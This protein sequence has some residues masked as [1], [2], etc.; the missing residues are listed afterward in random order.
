MKKAKRQNEEDTKT[1]PGS[2]PRLLTPVASKNGFVLVSVLWILAILTVITVGFGRRSMLDRRA[3][4]FS[5]DHSKALCMARG[6]VVR[7]VVELQNRTV[8]NALYHQIHRTGPTQYWAK[9]IDMMAQGFYTKLDGNDLPAPA[10]GS[11]AQGQTR[12]YCKATIRDEEGLISINTEK[13][14]E[15]LEEIDG[16]DYSLIRKINFRLTGTENYDKPTP[17]QTVEELRFL[18]DIDDDLW[19]GDGTRL[20]LKD[21]LTCWNFKN[22]NVNNFGDGLININ[23]A[24]REVLECIPEIDE[25]IVES[26]LAYRAG[27]DGEP[28]TDD[29]ADFIDFDHI[30]RYWLENPIPEE[31]IGQLKK[32]CKVE[33]NCFT[34]QGIATRRQGKVRALCSATVYVQDVNATIIKWREESLDS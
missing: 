9:P 2:N 15:L 11:A 8:V 33:S 17:F 28:G 27:T 30:N 25:D 7:G 22:G 3:A 32:Y 24:P 13:G 20:G 1:S 12:D 16:I 18:G 19:F 23:T 10:T 5:F 31:F 34:I 6:A 21:I 4:A 26:I 29:D 14:V